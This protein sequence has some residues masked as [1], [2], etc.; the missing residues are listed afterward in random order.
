MTGQPRKRLPAARLRIILAGKL[1]GTTAGHVDHFMGFVRGL[2]DLGHQVWIMDEVRPSRCTDADGQR[3]P[4]VAWAGRQHFEVIMRAYGCWDRACLIHGQGEATH[5]LSWTAA[6]RAADDA[7]LLILRSGRFRVESLLERVACRVYVDG[8]PGVPQVRFANGEDYY[9]LADYQHF[10][11][12]G[13]NVG[14]D[15][16]LVPLVDRRWEPT[17]W[18]VDLGAWRLN[19]APPQRG[20]TTISSWAEDRQ[21]I[22]WQGRGGGQKVRN[23][24]RFLNLPRFT[25]ELLEIAVTSDGSAGAAHLDEFRQAGW[26]VSDPGQLRTAA[27]YRAYIAGSRAEFSVAHNLYVAL[28]TG[29]FGDRSARYL[30]SGR[31][32]LLQSTGLERH[33]PVGEGLL[34]FRDEEEAVDGMRRINE[35]YPRHCRA[36]RAMALEY[37]DAPQVMRRLLARIGAGR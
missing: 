2:E 31:P 11:T 21:P 36:A 30:A 4:F 15:D 20:F 24:Q 9:R 5:G 25:A 13:L 8:N 34:T 17:M 16:C 6:Q 33:L 26:R 35:D 7:D 14:H 18:P 32:V 1:A 28:H 23:W 12:V 3:V 10:F 27:D 37:F 29:W 22:E 19:P